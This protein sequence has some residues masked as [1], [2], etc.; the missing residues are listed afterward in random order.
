[1]TNPFQNLL[2]NSTC[3]ATPRGYADFDTGA[4]KKFVIDPHNYT[5]KV[6]KV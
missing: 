4:A 3:A 2:S 5:G 1:M 6:K